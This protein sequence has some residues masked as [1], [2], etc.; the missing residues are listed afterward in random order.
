M[1]CAV[2]R[3]VARSLLAAL[4]AGLLAAVLPA[5]AAWAGVTAGGQTAGSGPASQDTKGPIGW[6]FYRDLNGA[7]PYLTRGVQQKSFSSFDRTG[8]NAD[9]GHCQATT[10][11]GGCVLAQHDG[12]GEVVAI[13]TTSNGGDVTQTGNI[14]IVLDGRTVLDA[15]EQSVVNGSVGAPFAYPL[16]ANAQQSSGGDYIMVPMPFRH[17]MEI[18]TDHNPDYYHVW[19]KSFASASGVTTFNPADAASSVIAMLKKAGTQDPK[20]PQPGATTQVTNFTLAPG[21]SARLATV[22]GPGEI[23]ALT[24]QIP[25]LTA[26]PAPAY[27]SDD[28]RAFQGYDQFTVKIDPS[29]QGVTLTRR[30]DAGVAGQVASVYVDGTKV[31]QWAP[32]PVQSSCRWANESVHLPASVTAGKSQITIRD[33]FVSSNI[34]FNAFYYWVYSIVNGRAVETD[35]LN[36]GPEHTAEEAAHSYTINDQTWP[37]AGSNGVRDYCYPPSS[38]SQPKVLATDDILQNVRL[39]ISFDDHQTVDAP[40]G[41]F[42]GSGLGLYPVKSLMYAMDPSTRTMTAWWPMPYREGATVTLYNGSK[43]AITSAQSQVTSAAEPQWAQALGPAGNAGYFHA[44]SNAQSTVPGKDYEFLQTAGW[45]KFVGETE[46]MRGPA[47]R[48]YLEGDAHVFVDGSHTPQI[49]GTGTEDFYQGGWYFD[50]GTFTDP[51]NGEPAHESQSDGCQQDCTGAYRLTLADAV[52]FQ[53]SI[54]FG[55]EHGPV[56]DVSAHYSSTAYWYGRPQE[57]QATTDTL[58]VGNA[59]SEAAH[60]YHSASPGTVTTLTATF[61]G[62]DGPYN[63]QPPMSLT[64]TLRATSSP[65]SFQM[66]VA[67]RNQGVTLWRLSDQDNGYQS[68]KVY[69]NG[70]DAGTWLE[71]LANPYHRWLDDFFQIPPS[72]TNGPAHRGT[73]SITLV[74]ASGSPAW[75]AAM[76]WTTS[77]VHPFTGRQPPSRSLGSRPR[78]PPPTTST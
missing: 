54:R 58:S 20:A 11:G 14:H 51:F 45:G 29:N 13:W 50:N 37:P 55:I 69:V 35:H 36:V 27:L 52:P 18:W 49:N 6:Q 19:Y 68:A 23:S 15:P 42:F 46:T 44:T 5:A 76:Y 9:F 34:D 28:G 56:D 73:I 67:P 41:Q 22:R 3:R 70:Q 21:A 7:L 1:N 62:D 53:S 8:G 30:L 48:V 26:P 63:G 43:Q 74:P 60:H 64:H 57:S 24:L 77:A 75:T 61:E 78:V 17:S 10:S 12:P 65:V 31:A 66:A 38:T 40:V 16:V 2:F 33:Q 32:N 4:A 47:S 25:Q 39:R 71:P 72:L 59:A